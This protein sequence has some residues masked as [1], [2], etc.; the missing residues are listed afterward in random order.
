MRWGIYVRVSSTDQNTSAQERELRRWLD[1]N[2]VP[3]DSVEWF[4]D[5]AS[6][7]DLHRPA[8][9][10]LQRAVFNG[11]VDAIAVWKLDR[12]SRNLRD[13][14]NTLADWCDRGLRVVSVTQQI[15]FN[16]A[17]GKMLAAVLLGIAEMERESIRERQA[18]GI[19]AAKER[20]IYSGRKRGTLKAKPKRAKELRARG[21]SDAEIA[22]ALGIS[23]RTVQRYLHA[24]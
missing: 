19:A 2:G 15:D 1:G 8:F 13:G 6:G 11:E 24:N 21:L 9:E 5:K 16:G 23:R 14:I 22:I 7:K 18:A 12:L 3:A 10:R 4:V 17:V 20:G